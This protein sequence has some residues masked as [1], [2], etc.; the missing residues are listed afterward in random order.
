MACDLTAIQVAACESQ[1][2]RVS[3]PIEL[4]QLTAQS[5]ATWLEAVSPGTDV[6]LE[7]IQQRACESGIGWE[8]NE[9]NLLRLIA[10]NLCN[11]IV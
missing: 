5:M 8:H 1:I 6:S 2:G 4:M 9:I 11:Q 7:A 3:D 10:Q